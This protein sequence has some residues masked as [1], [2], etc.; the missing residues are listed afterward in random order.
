MLHTEKTWEHATGIM[1]CCAGVRAAS[2]SDL[3]A[4]LIRHYGLRISGETLSWITSAH[5]TR[6]LLEYGR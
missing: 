1:R 5:Y 2:E 3:R 6:W 4:Q